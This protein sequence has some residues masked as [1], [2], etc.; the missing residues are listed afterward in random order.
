MEREFNFGLM[1]KLLD[2]GRQLT[3]R[4]PAPQ[5]HS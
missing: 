2:V 3:S 4:E 5:R 1:V